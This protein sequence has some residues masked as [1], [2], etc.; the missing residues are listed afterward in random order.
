MPRQVSA[1]RHSLQLARSLELQPRN[2][3]GLLD[4]AALALGLF[5]VPPPVTRGRGIWD[6]Q[7]ASSELCCAPWLLVGAHKAAARLP[8][9]VCSMP[10]RRSRSSPSAASPAADAPS[11][12]AVISSLPG[13][14]AIRIRSEETS[15]DVTVF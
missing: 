10:P 8:S 6:T 11:S 9:A 3:D 2:H 1:G 14:G 12:A 4:I 7:A 13:R 5:H 15:I